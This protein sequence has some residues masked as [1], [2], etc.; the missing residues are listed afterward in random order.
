MR[1]ELFLSNDKM[2]FWFNVIVPLIVVIIN[3]T[4][5]NFD[6]PEEENLQQKPGMGRNALPASCRFLVKGGL[7]APLYGRSYGIF[8]SGSHGD[9]SPGKP[10]SD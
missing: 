5:A 3:K 2:R 10:L 9:V 1:K 8:Q 7:Q 6:S 4:A